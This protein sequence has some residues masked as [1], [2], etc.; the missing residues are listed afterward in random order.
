MVCLNFS[1]RAINNQMIDTY[2]LKSL[3]GQFGKYKPTLS[4]DIISALPSLLLLITP[5]PPFLLPT[6]HIYVYEQAN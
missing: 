3:D 4:C 2:Q 6:L 5:S 1:Y